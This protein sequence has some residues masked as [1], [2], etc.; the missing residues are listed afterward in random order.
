ME[1]V[2]VRMGYIIA[3]V[4]VVVVVPLLFIFLSRRGRHAG[5]VGAD[6]TSRGVTVMEPSSDQPTPT[7]EATNRTS[8]GAEQRLPP[9]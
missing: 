4:F 8:P 9:G 2:Y 7:A 5:G 1:P 3:L 6:S